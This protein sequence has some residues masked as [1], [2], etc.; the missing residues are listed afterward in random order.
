MV[1]QAPEGLTL[2][3][4]IVIMIASVIVIIGSGVGILRWK[5]RNPVSTE[6]D[7]H[8]LVQKLYD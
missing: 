3:V 6:I 1:Y 2:T 8:G 5:L 7:D 4:A